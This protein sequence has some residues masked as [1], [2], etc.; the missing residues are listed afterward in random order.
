MDC[1]QADIWLV[2]YLYGEL[3]EQERQAFELHLQ[4]CSA[5]AK[6]VERMRAV[7]TLMRKDSR[8]DPSDRVSKE[9]VRAAE[10]SLHRT[11]RPWGWL[12][13]IRTP[14]AAAAALLVVIGIGAVV[15]FNEGFEK[16]SSESTSKVGTM[17]L[18]S[19][20]S[21]AGSDAKAPVVAA[22]GA[23]VS[24]DERT[25]VSEE[26]RSVTNKTP[27][28]QKMTEDMKGA[29][30]KERRLAREPIAQ[31]Q[32]YRNEG[33]SQDVGVVKPSERAFAPRPEEYHD[34]YAG[35]AGVAVAEKSAVQSL[36][37]ETALPATAAAAPRALHK[38]GLT[39]EAQAPR[40]APAEAV[41]DKPL[42]VVSDEELPS[43]SNSEVNAIM[44][45][46]QD[47]LSA[48]GRNY[49][50]VKG[51]AVFSLVI[52]TDG[53]VSSVSTLTEPFKGSAY[54]ECI[55]SHIKK[56]RFRQFGGELKTV[57]VSFIVK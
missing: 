32:T 16:R 36:K 29:G 57:P 27:S 24:K 52:A 1:S 14:L 34:Q 43:L 20:Q 21:L 8:E 37:Q 17:E 25:M 19:P 33:I 23:P 44:R 49:S 7:L 31:K 53:V 39:E 47:E 12:G 38:K 9:I 30:Q 54:A 35:S 6:E 46:H 10:A 11:S 56:I 40:S 55:S 3:P 22:T 48:C 45:A 42:G 15:Y 5:H 26:M 18:S 2:D 13:W 4:S 50:S 51:T 41:A 28:P